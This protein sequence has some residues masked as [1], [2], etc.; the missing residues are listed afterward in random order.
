MLWLVVFVGLVMFVLVEVMVG[1]LMMLMGGDGGV[2]V[3][4]VMYLWIV[5]LGV[6]LFLF[7][8]VG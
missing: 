1:L 5:V 2:Y 6:L 4:V 8:F 7:V 3:G